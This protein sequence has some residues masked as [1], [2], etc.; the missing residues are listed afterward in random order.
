MRH[1]SGDQHGLPVTAFR[2]Q[3]TASLRLPFESC[4]A[5]T[6]ACLVAQVSGVEAD[7]VIGTMAYRAVRVRGMPLCHGRCAGT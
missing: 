2:C 3:T 5:L 6:H 4:A 1:R 7:D